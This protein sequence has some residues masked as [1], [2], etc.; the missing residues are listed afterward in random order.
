MIQEEDSVPELVNL[1][2]EFVVRRIIAG[3]NVRTV[4]ALLQPGLRH[5]AKKTELIFWPGI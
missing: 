4:G 1:V 2:Q 5:L 3:L